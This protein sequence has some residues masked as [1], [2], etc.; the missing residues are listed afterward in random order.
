MACLQQYKGATD[1]PEKEY[2]VYSHNLS[3]CPV[4]IIIVDIG[5]GKLKFNI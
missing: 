3:V 1:D 2:T 4:N 5:S